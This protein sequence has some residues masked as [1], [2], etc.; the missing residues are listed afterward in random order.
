MKK[1]CILF[2]CHTD[3]LKKYFATLNNIIELKKYC[4]DII[5]INSIDSKYSKNIKEEL[6]DY[7]YI[8]EYFEIKNDKYLDFGKWIHALYNTNFF[9]I[10]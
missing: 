2:A 6:V 1:I 8:K 7:D 5:I 4:S 9:H 10:N 3:S